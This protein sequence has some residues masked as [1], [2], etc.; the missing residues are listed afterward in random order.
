[1]L[2]R[3]QLP[4]IERLH[5]LLHYDQTS[6]IFRWKVNVGRRIRAGSVAGSKTS[7]GAVRIQIDGV[8][9]YAHR[10]AWA[11]MT[12]EPV[13][14]HIDHKNCNPE[15]NDWEN[16]REATSRQNSMNRSIGK[17]NSSGA[18]GVV[19]NKKAKKWQAQVVS[20]MAS[21]YIG[22]FGDF[23]DAVAASEIARRMLHGEFARSR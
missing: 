9:Y 15:E 4:P 2:K 3:K 1:M 21:R 20:R 23:D 6:G 17:L 7:Q 16:L 14:D 11:M 19:W 22:L 13:P 8:A 18:K 12:G 5:E 10:I